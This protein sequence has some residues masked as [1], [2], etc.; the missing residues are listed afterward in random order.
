MAQRD[1]LPRLLALA[2]SLVL[3]T[4]ALFHSTGYPGVTAAVERGEV[5]GQLAKIVGPLWLFPSYHWIFAALVGA[6]AARFPGTISRV[7]LGLTAGLL[8]ADA[9]VILASVGPFLGEALLAVAALLFAAAALLRK[10]TGADPP[11]G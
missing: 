10:R 7:L 3:V 6:M 11:A 8:A 1:R 9:I 2:G 4:T 5:T